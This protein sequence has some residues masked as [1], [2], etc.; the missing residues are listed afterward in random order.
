MKTI[1]KRAKRHQK[2]S[3]PSGQIKNVNFKDWSQLFSTCALYLVA[4]AWSRAHF[5]T[6]NCCI[7]MNRTNSVQSIW[8]PD[9]GYLKDFIKL[10]IMQI[11]IFYAIIPLATIK[12]GD[13]TDRYTKMPYRE[14]FKRVS[15]KIDCSPLKNLTWLSL[16][17]AKFVVS[18]QA[19]LYNIRCHEQNIAISCST[20]FVTICDA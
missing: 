3:K 2:T 12:P 10:V 13:Y 18:A 17:V 15:Y 6:Q 14:R 4:T 11:A 9:S 8:N 19:A 5:C 7:P 20:L 1:T 16:I